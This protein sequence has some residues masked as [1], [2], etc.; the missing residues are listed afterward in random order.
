[1]S[2]IAINEKNSLYLDSEGN[3]AIARN[4]EAT[5]QDILTRLATYQ[6][7]DY[8]NKLFG[9]PYFSLLK[10]QVNVNYFIAI[11]QQNVL[12]C[13]NVVSFDRFTWDFDRQ[14][15]VL[16]I[17]FTVKAG[18]RSENFEYSIPSTGEPISVR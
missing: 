9:I 2:Q 4:E 1:M 16:N 18:M 14:A 6:G 8:I 12:Q 11:V 13:F 3:I 17:Y 10:K 7:E 5:R 15:R